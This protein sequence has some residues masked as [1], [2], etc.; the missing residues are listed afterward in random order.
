[1]QPCTVNPMQRFH[2]AL[3]LFLPKGLRGTVQQRKDAHLLWAG[4]QV[5]WQ[6]ATAPERQE[7]GGR[8]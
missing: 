8:Y 3:A 5:R 4:Y 1:M 7:V 6:R 2:T